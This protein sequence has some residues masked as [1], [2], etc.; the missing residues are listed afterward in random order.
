MGK[1]K[2]EEIKT[3]KREEIEEANLS[4]I[5]KEKE[6]EK[7]KK[8]EKEEENKRNTIN[9]EIYNKII[10]ESN[11]I[12]NHNF[13]A[14]TQEEQNKISAN[15]IQQF[16]NKSDVTPTTSTENLF[17]TGTGSFSIQNIT[18]TEEDISNL[19]NYDYL[20]DSIIN[21]YFKLKYSNLDNFQKENIGYL[22]SFFIS[23]LMNKNN[24]KKNI[25][26]MGIKEKT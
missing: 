25:K 12:K 1:E 3:K 17:E 6:K 24:T 11:Q 5:N 26:K 16:K 10:N 15:V 23:K 20:S 4:I 22:N 2:E 19:K 8:K 18:N 21:L 14:E 9:L 7:E 13:K